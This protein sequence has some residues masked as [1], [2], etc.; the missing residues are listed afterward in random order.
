MALDQLQPLY[1]FISQ[2]PFQALIAYL[3]CRGPRKLLD[4]FKPAVAAAYEFCD[5][6]HGTH[7]EFMA[8]IG[9]LPKAARRTRRST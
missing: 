7:C 2:H 8:G 6:C 4:L 3:A 1:N 9:S 5:Y